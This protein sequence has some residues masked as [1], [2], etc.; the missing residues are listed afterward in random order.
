MLIRDTFNAND[1][2]LSQSLFTSGDTKFKA[3]TALEPGEGV[4]RL[5]NPA[6]PVSLQLHEALVTLFRRILPRP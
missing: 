3:R 4:V 6:S 1:I 2:L 5:S